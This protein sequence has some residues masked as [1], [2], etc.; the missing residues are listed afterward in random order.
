MSKKDEEEEVEMDMMV[1]DWISFVGMFEL[2]GCRWLFG[3]LERK[4]WRRKMGSVGGFTENESRGIGMMARLGEGSKMDS[5]LVDEVGGLA[6]MK[7][8]GRW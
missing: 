3:L 4:R 7:D 1:F 2:I 6:M 5:D 8:G